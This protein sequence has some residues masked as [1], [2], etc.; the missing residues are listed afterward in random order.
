MAET[1]LFLFMHHIDDLAEFEI[2]GSLGYKDNG[3]HIKGSIEGKG[4]KNLPL[5]MFK[6]KYPT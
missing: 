6:G 5:C 2:G 1:G 3:F 4:I